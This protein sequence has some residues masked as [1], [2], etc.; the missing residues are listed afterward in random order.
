MNL[1][2]GDFV[3]EFL[4]LTEYRCSIIISEKTKTVGPVRII[5]FTDAHEVVFTRKELRQIA[6]FEKVFPEIVED[7]NFLGIKEEF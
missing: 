3:V 2:N 7:K 4:N 1:L 6:E 5:E